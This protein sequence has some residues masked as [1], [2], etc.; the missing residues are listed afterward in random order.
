MKAAETYEDLNVWEGATAAVVPTTRA[1]LGGVRTLAPSARTVG[2]SSP[3]RQNG[4]ALGGQ[5]Q[6]HDGENRTENS[7]GENTPEGD[8]PA[9]PMDKL[10]PVLADIVSTT[11]AAKHVSRELVL[12]AALGTMS[13]SACGRLRVWVPK[14]D[15]GFDQAAVLYIMAAS[16]TGTRKTPVVS[17]ITAPLYAAQKQLRES[18]AEEIAGASALKEVAKRRADQLSQ[19][20]AKSGSVV[21]EAEA[22]SARVNH[23][24]LQVPTLPAVLLDEATME[25][26]RRF[27]ADQSGRAAIVTSEGELIDIIG[28][29]YSDRAVFTALLRGYDGLDYTWARSKS[30]D[31]GSIEHFTVALCL[32]VQPTMVLDATAVPGGDEKGFVARLM[33]VDCPS[34]GEEPWLTPPMDPMAAEAWAA[35]IGGMVDRFWGLDEPF[36][37][38]FD[39]DAAEVSRRVFEDVERSKHHGDLRLATEHANK[40]HGL[41]GRLAALIA[42]LQGKRSVGKRDAEAAEALICWEV[43][44]HLRMLRTNASTKDAEEDKRARAMHHWW[45]TSR[46]RNV[47][48]V[49]MPV[50][51]FQQGCKFHNHKLTPSEVRSALLLLEESYGVVRC[52]YEAGEIVSGDLTGELG[53]E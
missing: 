43:A 21:D 30:A 42:A 40:L 26:L 8:L 20:A 29:L 24:L 52:N 32:V 19:A 17:A 46:A 22:V 12:M 10:P 53:D 36:D 50:T 1:L 16:A 6:E 23:D 39:D 38:C 33:I 28:G 27:A 45:S 34:M 9:V 47:V 31:G 5:L 3:L 4:Q 11:A 48:R 49:G 35:A 25:G 13:A 44:Y 51:A 41:F 18:A 14:G 37:M 2:P 15:G 7:T